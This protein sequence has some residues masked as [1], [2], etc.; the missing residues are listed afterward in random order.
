MIDEKVNFQEWDKI[1]SFMNKNKNENPELAKEENG[2]YF[3]DQE[4]IKRCA[5]C[6]IDENC[7]ICYEC[8]IELY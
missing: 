7:P 2:S 5:K 3:I 8:G 6:G 4:G 1:E